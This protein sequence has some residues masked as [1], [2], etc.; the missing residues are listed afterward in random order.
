MYIDLFSGCGG[1]AL[2]LHK[3]GWN[4]LFA[5][6]KSADAFATLQHNLIDN[7]SNF[8]WPT[9]LPKQNHDINKIIQSYEKELKALQGKNF[10]GC[11]WTT[12]S[13]VLN[14]REKKRKR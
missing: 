14:G 8:S 3:A 12:L 7:N 11:W 10:F 5:I 2:G 4:G 1:L 6:E 9:W 13:R